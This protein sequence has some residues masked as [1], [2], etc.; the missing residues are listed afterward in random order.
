MRSLGRARAALGGPLRTPALPAPRRGNRAAGVARS[1]LRGT[2]P[3]G[4]LSRAQ[5][6]APPL[7]ADWLTLE[8]TSWGPLF[9]SRIPDL[10]PLGAA[11]WRGSCLKF[12]SPPSQGLNWGTVVVHVFMGVKKCPGPEALPRGFPGIC[13]GP[14]Q[15]AAAS[16]H[17]LP[18]FF[19]SDHIRRAESPTLGRDSGRWLV[20]WPE[21]SGL[22]PPRRGQN[23]AS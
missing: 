23:E 3:P 1:A 7:R 6:R 8:S 2:P 21:S 5:P 4:R 13:S 22:A 19:T 18:L 16:A 10:G 9:R 17:F 12:V 14:G 20:L 15:R 11:P